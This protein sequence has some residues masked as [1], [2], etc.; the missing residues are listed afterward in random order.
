M[1]FFISIGLVC[2]CLFSGNAHCHDDTDYYHPPP[3]IVDAKKEPPLNGQL[4]N[5]WRLYY[6]GT[7]N[8]T[9]WTAAEIAEWRSRYKPDETWVSDS[10][11]PCKKCSRTE[12]TLMDYNGSE[13]CVDKT[14]CPDDFTFGK[15]WRGTDG[16][17]QCP[18][19]YEFDDGACLWDLI[20]GSIPPWPD[21]RTNCFT[22]EVGVRGPYAVEG[23]CWFPKT[24]HKK[25]RIFS[26]SV[27]AYR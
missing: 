9:C 7:S 17:I 19:N 5:T 8:P 12:L 20:Y 13:A 1:K 10:F 24:L 25:R 22:G 6:D 3:N 27:K 2:I 4:V 26:Q 21:P 15:T 23:G 14:S 11:G 18:G 16:C